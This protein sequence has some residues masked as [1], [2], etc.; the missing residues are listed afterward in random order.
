[1]KEQ[2]QNC[3]CHDGENDCKAHPIEWA[4]K[5]DSFPLLVIRGLN[6]TCPF[7]NTNGVL[8]LTQTYNLIN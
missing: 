1:M 6:G 2:K 8:D 5:T 7:D 4:F 3:N